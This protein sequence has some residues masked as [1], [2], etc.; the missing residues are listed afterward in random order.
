[1]NQQ[2]ITSSPARPL[3]ARGALSLSAGGDL[4]DISKWRLVRTH[5]RSARDLGLL[6]PDLISQRFL[7]RPIQVSVYPAAIGDFDDTL[8]I[9]TY[10]RPANLARALRMA[11]AEDRPVMLCGQPLALAELLFDHMRA[12]RALP[13]RVLILIGGYQCPLGL[14]QRLCDRLT[15][16]GVLHEVIHGYGA[17]EVAPA[18]LVG[19]RTVDGVIH[20]RLAAPNVAVEINDGRLML[21]RTDIDQAPVDTGDFARSRSVDGQAGWLIDP[22]PARLAPAVRA[23]LAS[24]DARDWDRRTGYIAQADDGLYFQLR[25]G[26]SP[27]SPKELSFASFEDRHQNSLLDK[28]RWGV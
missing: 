9:D 19:M 12:G 22:S 26:V 4:S 6:F 10:L 14:E 16:A 24:W 11:Y 23:A 20:Y 17:A 5:S 15:Q 27:E 2:A 18:C 25:R 13:S 3:P 28:P 1:M 7:D 8:F 21:R